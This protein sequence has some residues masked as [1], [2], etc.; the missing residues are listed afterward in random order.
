MSK[1]KFK[2]DKKRDLFFDSVKLNFDNWNEISKL[3]NINRNTLLRYKTGECLIPYETFNVLKKFSKLKDL[4]KEIILMDS[5]WGASLGGKRNCEKNKWI[6]EKGRKKLRDKHRKTDK[7]LLDLNPNSPE[8]A[9]FMGVL[10]GDGFIGKY[11]NNRIIQITGHKIKDKEYYVN[12]LIPLIKRIFHIDPKF[13]TRDTCIR[14]TIHSKV[15]F[16]TINKKF[17]FPIGKKHDISMHRSLIK[18]QECKIALIRGLFDTDGYVGL[19]RKKYPVIEITTVSK[20]LAIQ[21]KDILNELDFGAYICKNR[22][23]PRIAFRVTL[24]GKEKLL[25]WQNLIGSSNPCKFKR[26]GEASVAQII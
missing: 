13:Y 23:S 11:G 22:S 14:L 5:H 8:L 9:E 2:S 7:I 18:T 1:V 17:D 26:I 19:Q 15:I 20:P 10:I 16:N 25:K 4:D 6:Y 12:Y 21:V 24:F 3:L